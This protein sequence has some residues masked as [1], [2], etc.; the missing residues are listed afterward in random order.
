MNL[1]AGP[2][3]GKSTIAA[4]IFCAL[5]QR[6]M[7]CELALEY[8]KEVLWEGRTQLLENQIYIFAKQLQRLKRLEGKVDVIITDS[9]LMLSVIYSQRNQLDRVSARGEVF[10]KLVDLT[11]R[12]FQNLDF[13]ITR[14]EA[15][16]DPQ[17]R[18]QTAEEA[19]KIDAEVYAMLEEHGEDFITLQSTS[20]NRLSLV[21]EEAVDAICCSLIP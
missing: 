21:V 4:G 16:Y 2:G 8:A 5:K 20:R 3:A 1:F 14:D 9:P 7:N 18:T 19:K 17:G 12:Q 15:F 6:G 10:R 13:Y 11:F